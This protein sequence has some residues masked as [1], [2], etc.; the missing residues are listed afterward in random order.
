MPAARFQTRHTACLQSWRRSDSN[1]RGGLMNHAS[2][3]RSQWCSVALAASV[4]ALALSAPLLSRPL[5]GGAAGP[6]WAQEALNPPAREFA[7]MA[8]DGAGS[9]IVLF[10]GQGGSGNLGDTWTWNGATWT[11]PATATNPS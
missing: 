11:E 6:T 4:V 3:R 7:T 10:G 9:S 2:T 5:G 8:Y 1:E